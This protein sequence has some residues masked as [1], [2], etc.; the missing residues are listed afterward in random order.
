MGLLRNYLSD[1]DLYDMDQG[2]G[3]T[4]TSKMRATGSVVM[5]PGESVQRVRDPL[6]DETAQN[7]GDRALRALARTDLY[8][9]PDEPPSNNL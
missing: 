1:D 6:S 9:D 7:F 3:E 4:M 2:L 5:P 8:I